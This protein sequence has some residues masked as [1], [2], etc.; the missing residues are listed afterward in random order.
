MEEAMAAWQAS[1]SSLTMYGPLPRPNDAQD[2]LRGLA[3]AKAATTA[4]V[5]KRLFAGTTMA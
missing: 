4:M 2:S 1:N 5:L 3:L